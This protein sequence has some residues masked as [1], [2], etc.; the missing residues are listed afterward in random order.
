MAVA[1]GDFV[2][3]LDGTTETA[4]EPALNEMH[5]WVEESYVLLTDGG[6]GLAQG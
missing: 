4:A 3:F 1:L 2:K 5:Q 6:S